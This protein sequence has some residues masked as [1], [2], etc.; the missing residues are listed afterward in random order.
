[1]QRDFTGYV[2]K[3]A[4]VVSAKGTTAQQ[5]MPLLKKKPLPGNGTSC[6]R[7]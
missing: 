5:Q 3:A 7:P 4:V 1:M 2:G 6:D